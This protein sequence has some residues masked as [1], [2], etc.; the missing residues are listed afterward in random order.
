[1]RNTDY[2][3]DFGLGYNFGVDNPMIAQYQG[4]SE[5]PPVSGNFLLL[6]GSDFK[7]LDGSSLLLL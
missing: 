1:M 6:D 5:F 7:L 3:F 2:D 4:H